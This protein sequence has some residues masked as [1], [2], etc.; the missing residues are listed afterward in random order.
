MEGAIKGGIFY[1]ERV[2]FDVARVVFSVVKV[3]SGGW[4]NKCLLM[5]LML[6]LVFARA[7]YLTEL[8]C[9]MDNDG[10]PSL[11]SSV[12]LAYFLYEVFVAS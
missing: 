12:C 3:S 11:C 7:T 8:E 4:K 2:V 9:D 10:L 1:Y 6:I 5:L